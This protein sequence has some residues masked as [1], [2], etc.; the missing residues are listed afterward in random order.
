MRKLYRVIGILGLFYLIVGCSE[1]ATVRVELPKQ[2]EVM[3][4]PNAITV[5][6]EPNLP[7]QDHLLLGWLA[8]SQQIQNVRVNEY[9]YALQSQQV[10]SHFYGTLG[11]TAMLCGTILLLTIIVLQYRKKTL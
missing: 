9:Q 1:K 6:F 11:V 8:T 2:N 7:L 3:L 10:E 4:A 5:R